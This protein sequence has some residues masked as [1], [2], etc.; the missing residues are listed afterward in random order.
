M[1]MYLM[2]KNNF[3]NIY[4]SDYLQAKTYI[5]LKHCIQDF[6]SKV[7]AVQLLSHVRLLV[8][9]WTAAHQA[10]LSITNSQSLLKLMS[11]ESVI[12]QEHLSV[13]RSKIQ[14]AYSLH[15]FLLCL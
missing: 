4:C 14:N 11:I 12:G 2:L 1:C 8:T 3:E 7:V 9:P 13:P 15:G 10:S 6:K 5:Y